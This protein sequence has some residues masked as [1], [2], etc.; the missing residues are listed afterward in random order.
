MV[1][2]D[3]EANIQLDSIDSQKMLFKHRQNS[4]KIHSVSIRGY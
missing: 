1:L 2:S 3:Y 4:N